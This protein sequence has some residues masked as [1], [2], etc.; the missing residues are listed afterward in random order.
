MRIKSIYVNNFKS[1]VDFKIDLAKFNALI[2][3]NGS[4]KST[5]LQFVDFLSHLMKGD[6]DDWLKRREWNQN[7]ILSEFSGEDKIIRFNI[8]IES[9]DGCS[10]SWKANYNIQSQRCFSEV[11]KVDNYTFKTCKCKDSDLRCYILYKDGTEDVK[12]NINFEYKGSLLSCLRDKNVPTIFW[13][14]RNFIRKISSS[15]LISP[16][17]LRKS[18]RAAHGT[19]GVGGELLSAML[20][21]LGIDKILKIQERIKSICPHL[22]NVDIKS[23][24]SGWKK[25]SIE[26]KFLDKK[27]VTES[28]HVNDGL[29]RIIAFLAQLESKSPFLLFDEIENGINPELIAFLLGELINSEKQIVVTTHSPI[30]LNFLDDETAI[31]GVHFFYKTPE[32]FTKCVPFLSIPS[33]REKLDFMGPGE[34]LIDTDLTEL[35]RQLFENGKGA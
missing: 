9:S 13:D 8:Q 6:V 31:P 20:F 34:A 10:F 2:G 23:L 21:E 16:Q 14:A 18:A 15:D 4:G 3:L 11:L 32:G 24:R 19:I 1:L 33:M 17:Y 28:K 25:L 30:I 26:E 29:L 5:F 7:D 12:E 27:L 35:S 22:C